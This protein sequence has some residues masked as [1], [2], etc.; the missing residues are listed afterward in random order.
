MERRLLA[1][2]DCQQIGT[3][4]DRDGIWSFRYAPAWPASCAA[5]GPSSMW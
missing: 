5:C 3:L 1:W 2:I 4:R